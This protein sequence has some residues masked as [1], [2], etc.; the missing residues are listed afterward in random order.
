MI[1]A[2]EHFPFRADHASHGGDAE[3]GPSTYC[4]TGLTNIMLLIT[5]VVEIKWGDKAERNLERIAIFEPIV[6]YRQRLAK[7]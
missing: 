6:H 5:I 7:L 3:I 1:D 4:C 2:A